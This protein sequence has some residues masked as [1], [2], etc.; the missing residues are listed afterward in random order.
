MG[1]SLS[2]APGGRLPVVDDPDAMPELPDAVAATLESAFAQSNGDGFL[3][4]KPQG[5][6]AIR[7]GYLRANASSDVFAVQQQQLTIGPRGLPQLREARKSTA[8]AGHRHRL[9][10]YG[11]PAAATPASGGHEK[12]A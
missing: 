3:F 1:K 7:G 4:H 11:S 10:P 9:A 5:T 12:R 6:L 8:R 2:I